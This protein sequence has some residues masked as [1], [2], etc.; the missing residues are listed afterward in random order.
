MS[1]L[2]LHIPFCKQAC[3]YCNFH[4]STQKDYR[5]EMVISM[6]K[7]MQNRSNELQDTYLTSVYFGGGTPSILSDDEMDILWNGI[8]KYFTINTDAEVTIEANPDDIT[9]EKLSY[10]KQTPINR[11][12]MGVQSFF[13]EDLKWMNR[14]HKGKDAENAIKKIQDTGFDKITIDL[15]YGLPTLTNKNWEQNLTK[16]IALNLLH[17]SAYCLTIEPKTALFQQIKKGKLTQPDEEKAVAQFEY[18]VSYLESN[19][20]EQYEIS[21]FAKNKQYALHNTNYW[22]NKP[23]LGIGPSAH[24]FNCNTRSWNFSNNHKYMLAVNAGKD[25]YETEHLTD[26]NKINEYIMTGLRT[27]W[28]CNWVEIENRFGTS[29]REILNQKIQHFIANEL[30]Y[31]ND[32]RFTLTR[33]GRILADGIASDLFF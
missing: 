4:F 12:S 20:F 21:N 10:Y 22:L 13:D 11:F 14:V 9:K 32:E 26:E 30:I 25:A 23:Y 6:V 24:S 5:K 18:M 33:K 16:A 15:I 2:Y 7:E 3:N 8:T 31:S 27:I 1:S 19:N 29:K 28:G 17:I